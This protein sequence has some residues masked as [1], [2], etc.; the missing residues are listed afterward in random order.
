MWRPAPA[1]RSVSPPA[2]VQPEEFLHAPGY[3]LGP[4]A[5]ATSE[6]RFP[7]D[8]KVS[9]PVFESYSQNGEDVVLWRA[10][11]G[12]RTGRY[13]DVGANHPR[14]D[15][16]SMAFY[17]RGWSGITVEPDPEFARLQ[18][19]Q[20]PRDFQVDAAGNG[21]DVRNVTLHVVDGTGLSTLVDRFAQMHASSGY[22]THDVT[23][24]TRRI[25]GILEESGWA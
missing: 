24:P 14:D 6:V 17:L 1:R 19:E 5:L 16:V 15:S 2:Q 3:V 10:L 9:A 18:R 21:K 22:Q 20:R 25:D 11:E 13:I 4:S 12:V 7:Y 8:G 23:V